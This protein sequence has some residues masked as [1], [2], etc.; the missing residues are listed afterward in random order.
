MKRRRNETPFETDGESPEF[1]VILWLS[2]ETQHLQEAEAEGC[3][4]DS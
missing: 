1:T 2:S 3:A 4:A